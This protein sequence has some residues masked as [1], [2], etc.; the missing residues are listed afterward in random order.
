MNAVGLG[1]ENKG[2][3]PTIVEH[4]RHWASVTPTA[5]ALLDS[6]VNPLSYQNI[7]LQ[8]DKLGAILNGEG[9]EPGDRVAIVHSGGPDAAAAIIGIC[10]YASVAPLNPNYIFGEFAIQF[11]DLGIK[12]VAIE[13]DL[14]TPALKVAS[15]LGLPIF[16]IQNIDSKIAGS[17]TL[18]SKGSSIPKQNI[19]PSNIDDEM[20]VL[21]TS[22]TTNQNK[23]VPIFQRHMLTRG[24]HVSRALGF[25]PSDRGINFMPL[26]HV[27][28]LS[29]GITAALY[30]GSSLLPMKIDEIDTFFKQLEN[31]APTYIAASPTV[32]HSIAKLAPRFEAIIQRARPGIRM[33]RTGAGHLNTT[34]AHQLEEMFDAP[35]IEA[36][37]STETGFI[38]CNSLQAEKRKLGSVGLSCGCDIMIQQP[39]ETPSP[40]GISG[41]VVVRGKNIIDN[42][43]G[44]PA[45]TQ[46]AFQGE[47]YR[48]GDLGKLDDEGYLFLKGRLKEVIRRGG[49]SISPGEIES[50]LLE[51]SDVKEAIIFGVPHPT[52]GED[53]G[54]VVV[55]IEG[56]KVTKSDLTSFLAT[57]VSVYKIPQE[58]IFV[59][60]IPTGDTGKVQRRNLARDLGLLNSEKRVVQNPGTEQQTQTKVEKQLVTLWAK[61]LDL[62]TVGLDDNFFALGGDSLQAVELFLNIEEQL[63]Q[64]L[65]RSIL[66]EAGS[67]SELAS[68]IEEE[69]TPACVVAIQPK[70]VRLPIFAIHPIGGTVICYRDLAQLIGNHQPFYGVQCISPNGEDGY[71]ASLEIMATHYISEIRKFQPTGPYSISGHSFGGIVAYEIAQQLQAS[72][73]K[74]ALLAIIDNGRDFS[75]KMIKLY[76]WL[77]RNIGKLLKTNYKNWWSLVKTGMTQWYRL[78]SELTLALTKES[79][80]EKN[81]KNR[82][83]LIHHGSEKVVAANERIS[84]AYKPAPYNGDV[85]LFQAQHPENVRVAMRKSWQYMIKGNLEFRDILGDHITLLHK[86]HVESLAKEL[87]V[88]LKGRH[89]KESMK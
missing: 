26:Y 70:G 7:S 89:P 69:A 19:Q 88:V 16:E 46:A 84:R 49:Q 74:V 18:K 11:Q 82:F 52:L 2:V 3:Q 47:W 21:A 23:I 50:S 43:D 1:H 20:F 75:P 87:E 6:E 28:G 62:E 53:I 79:G 64:R 61:A 86:P 22:G 55:P 15:K 32:F 14:D 25:V 58:I 73:E 71:F 38:A 80:D 30:S 65:P 77:D 4:I 66:F 57:R 41:E 51:H 17:I 59:E 81:Q 67:V 85:V 37:G 42:Y 39:D 9:I 13:A 5:P 36:Y 31:L 8:C 35:V 63:G 78:I 24:H 60:T 34:I 76:N 40:V 33:L 45:G 48:T 68:R 27:G 12:A 44:D 10:A 56:A 83:G 29:A 72:G 54:V